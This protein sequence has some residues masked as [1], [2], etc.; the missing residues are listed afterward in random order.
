[1]VNVV[2]N[3]GQWN[4]HLK[5]FEALRQI[6]RINKKKE[7]LLCVE[8]NILTFLLGYMRILVFLCQYLFFPKIACRYLTMNK[9]YIELRIFCCCC[10]CC[11]CCKVLL[12]ILQ[13]ILLGN[14]IDDICSQLKH[15]IT[16][17]LLI[18]L[19]FCLS[20]FSFFNNTIIL[21]VIWGLWLKLIRYFQYYPLF[22]WLVFCF[23][24]D[25]NFRRWC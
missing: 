21:T 11:C 24:T 6:N 4:I 13:M 9:I 7:F 19:F 3:A 15:G 14:A 10:C 18:I 1:M 16:L 2:I 17:V 23:C 20:F 25:E 8:L 5:Y 22:F 12:C